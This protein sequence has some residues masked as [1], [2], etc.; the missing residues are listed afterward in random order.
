[1]R[2]NRLSHGMLPTRDSN[3]QM[4]ACKA[5]LQKAACFHPNGRFHWGIR[6]NDMRM[7]KALATGQIRTWCAMNQVRIS[8]LLAEHSHLEVQGIIT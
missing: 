6:L 7:P 4:Y 5:Y 1:M 3:T 8:S 2:I